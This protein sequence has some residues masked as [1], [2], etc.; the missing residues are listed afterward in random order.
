G[1]LAEADGPTSV[2]FEASSRFSRP[3]ST[4]GPGAAVVAVAGPAPLPLSSI[5]PTMVLMA[6]VFPS[7]TNTSDKTPATG[8][9]ISVSTLSVEISNSG[10]S[11]STRSPFFFSHFVRVPS[12]ILSPIWGITI[13]VIR[14]LRSQPSEAQT[15][16]LHQRRHDLL[17]AS[18]DAQLSHGR[19]WLSTS[20]WHDVLEMTQICPMFQR[21]AVR[22]SPA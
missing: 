20:A 22:G 7:S 18:L 14:I 16:S 8:A 17:A 5:L 13:S 3:G 11:R 4:A 10:S 6:T 15:E 12:T 19:N 9:G 2:G 1:V 21:N